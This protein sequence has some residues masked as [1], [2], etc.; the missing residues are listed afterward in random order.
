MA[1]GLLPGPDNITTTDHNLLPLTGLNIQAGA[2]EMNHTAEILEFNDLKGEAN[3]D[4][5]SFPVHPRRKAQYPQPAADQVRPRSPPDSQRSRAP[6]ERRAPGVPPGGAE[7]GC[8]AEASPADAGHQQNTNYRKEPNTLTGAPPSRKVNGVQAD[9]QRDARAHAPSQFETAQEPAAGSF[10]RMY[11]GSKTAPR[12]AGGG[13]RTGLRAPLHPDNAGI[14]SLN[15]P[16]RVAPDVRQRQ[17]AGPGS[18]RPPAL[19]GGAAAQG[20]RAVTWGR[21]GNSARISPPAFRPP[22]SPAF[23]GA[24]VPRGAFPGPPAGAPTHLGARC[25]LRGVPRQ[26]PGRWH[27]K[28]RALSSRAPAGSWEP[29]ARGRAHGAHPRRPLGTRCG[30]RP[31]RSQPSPR[32]AGRGDPVRA[33]S[34]P[35][36]PA[37]PAPRGGSDAGS[38]A[39]WRASGDR[40]RGPVGGS[41]RGGEGALG[42]ARWAGGGEER[43]VGG[44]RRQTAPCVAGP[45][46]AETPA[47]PGARVRALGTAAAQP[48]RAHP[49]ARTPARVPPPPPS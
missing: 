25:P 33:P 30:R 20:H 13:E 18:L 41:R 19:P 12:A 4:H 11:P 31:L 32:D 44:R 27:P 6:L 14:C 46:A 35:V 24:L 34:A 48:P 43:V 23:P 36:P 10:A 29:R 5:S 17:L 42:R 38:G 39:S 9:G 7:A 22:R 8:L 2:P 28:G 15:S 37:R 45:G 26:P 16:T 3:K 47:P 1:T 49:R 40:A 21:R